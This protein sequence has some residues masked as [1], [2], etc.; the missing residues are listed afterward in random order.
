MVWTS[1]NIRTPDKW[2]SFK[3]KKQMAAMAWLLVQICNGSKL[4]CFI[5]TVGIRI[6]GI[7]MVTFWVRLSN[8]PDI[9]CPGPDLFVQ[10][11]NGRNK[12]TSLDRFSMNKIFLLLF[13]L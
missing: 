11:S 6:P 9:E 4:D 3:V 5:Y 10:F 8:G 13:S 7:Q 12:I 1:Y 2:S